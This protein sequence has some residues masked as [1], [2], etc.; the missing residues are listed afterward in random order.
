[1]RSRHG[2]RSEPT[3]Q[4][5]QDV[6]NSIE[7]YPMYLGANGVIYAD[8]RN[9]TPGDTFPEWHTSCRSAEEVRGIWHPEWGISSVTINGRVE[10]A[11]GFANLVAKCGE[12]VWPP[13]HFLPQLHASRYDPHVKRQAHSSGDPGTPLP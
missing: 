3:V 4:E 10:V 9:P 2:R 5:L 11:A 1:M 7:S 8:P 12:P 6:W 13:G